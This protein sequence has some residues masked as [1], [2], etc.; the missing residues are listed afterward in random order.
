M[1]EIYITGV[2]PFTP[3]LCRFMAGEVAYSFLSVYLEYEFVTYYIS[4]VKAEDQFV[5]TDFG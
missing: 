2:C 1:W 4:D 5:L 3:G